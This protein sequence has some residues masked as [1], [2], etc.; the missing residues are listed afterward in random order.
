MLAEDNALLNSDDSANNIS[1]TNVG[2]DNI[3]QVTSVGEVTVPATITTVSL[4]VQAQAATAAEVQQE[5]SEQTANVVD[6]LEELDVQELQTTSVQLFP[7][8]SF[9]N[10]TQ[11]L[12]GFEARNTLQ[13]ELPTDEAGVAID[14]AIGA[15]ANLVQNI[16]FSASDEALQQARSEALAEAVQF[17]LSEAQTVFNVLD[18]VPQQIVG[19]EIL[20]TNQSNPFTPNLG[21]N[22][23]AEVLTPIIGGSQTVAATVN[24]DILYTRASDSFLGLE[25]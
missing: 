11:T 7:I 4:G 12:T 25:T 13:F 14:Q 17:A 5:V 9:E 19:I 24:L 23:D 6:V 20:S 16:S 10:E 22:A 3:L 15:G 8:Y 21:F 2:D 18:L 1:F